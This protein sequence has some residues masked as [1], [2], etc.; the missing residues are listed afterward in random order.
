MSVY[1]TDRG[2]ARTASLLVFSPVAMPMKSIASCS[3]ATRT[4]SSLSDADGVRIACECTHS[5]LPDADGMR[6]LYLTGRVSGWLRI[7]ILREGI[8]QPLTSSSLEYISSYIPCPTAPPG[9]AAD[10]A[11]PGRGTA[12]RGAA[13]QAVLSV[14]AA[15]SSQ[16]RGAVEIT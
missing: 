11:A 8:V 16:G 2:G 5:S 7:R 6:M 13:V 4:H 10:L 9:G 12:P 14:L 3:P 15:L 1:Q